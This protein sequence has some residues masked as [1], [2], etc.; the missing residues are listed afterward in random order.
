MYKSPINLQI[1]K[2]EDVILNTS[3]YDVTA[4]TFILGNIRYSL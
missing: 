1:L 4:I 2:N 3:I